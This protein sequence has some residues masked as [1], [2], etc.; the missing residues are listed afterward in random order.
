MIQSMAKQKGIFCLEGAWEG[1]LK[2]NPSV[3][4]LLDLLDQMATNKRR[5]VYRDVG[6]LEE[7]D[8]YLKVVWT[9]SR[10]HSHPILYL[11]FHGVPGGL[12]VGDQRRQEAVVSLDHIETLVAG[13]L[14]R[15]IVHF[16][17]CQTLDIHG[18]RLNHFL[19]KTKALAVC[20]YRKAIP[21]TVS[22]ALDLVLFQQLQE[23]ALVVPGVLAAK[24]RIFA[25]MGK[26]ARDLQFTMVVNRQS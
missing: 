18:N 17:S 19:T 10:Y 2:N 20:G 26:L 1:N 22:A 13:K 5:H 7:F 12:C 24:R 11:A 23:N 16:G 4:P 6:T 15:R 25:Q 9:Q 14:K 21:W 3:E 8:Y